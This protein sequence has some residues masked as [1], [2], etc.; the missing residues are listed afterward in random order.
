MP[1]PI[2]TLPVDIVT[3]LA[4]EFP[5]SADVGL[6]TLLSEFAAV[7]QF[8][9]IRCILHLASG[10]AAKVRHYADI[11]RQDSR[12]ILY[13][14]EYDRDDNRIHDFRQPFAT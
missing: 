3:R 5:D 10:D 8:R 14:A 4:R 7:Q 13:W 9:E 2:A 1:T 6:A 12:D 11:A